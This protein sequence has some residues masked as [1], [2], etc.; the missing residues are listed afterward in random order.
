MS[1]TMSVTW[2]GQRRRREATAHQ[3]A[4]IDRA[5]VGHVRDVVVDGFLVEVVGV[6]LLDRDGALRALAQAGAQPVAEVV[7]Q[8]HGLAA[9]DLDGALGAGRHAVAT[10][11]AQVLVDVHDLPHSHGRSLPSPCLSCRMRTILD[12]RVLFV[13]TILIPYWQQIRSSPHRRPHG[14][15]NGKA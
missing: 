14:S 4:E 8:Q 5:H 7:G 1:V 13:K 10:A 15:S 12:I 3:R 11:V 6:A 9:D 2:A